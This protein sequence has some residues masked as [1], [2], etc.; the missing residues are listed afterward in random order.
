MR[1][2]KVLRS[3]DAGP[4]VEG[5]CQGGGGEQLK[6]HFQYSLLFVCKIE[7][8]P[9][10][11]RISHQAKGWLFDK[12]NMAQKKGIFNQIYSVDVAVME[13]VELKEI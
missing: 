6:R 1:C 7:H 13:W 2:A 12:V 4:A 8:S 11:R 5:V 3:Q 10:C 9:W